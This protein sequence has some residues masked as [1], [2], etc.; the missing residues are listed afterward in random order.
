MVTG[1]IFEQISLLFSHFCFRG[2][3]LKAQI[4]AL[5][6][7]LSG[8]PKYEFCRR[9]GVCV[10][11]CLCVSFILSLPPIRPF[12]TTDLCTCASVRASP[13]VGVVE[14]ANR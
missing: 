10:G 11:V 6:M 13:S 8:E 4:S 7:W 5:R 3:S 12:P 1:F 14:I 9:E 2:E